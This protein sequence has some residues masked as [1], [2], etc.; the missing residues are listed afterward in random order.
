MDLTRH[1]AN[2][3]P[4]KTERANITF[5][6]DAGTKVAIDDAL[7]TLGVDRGKFF[8]S[9]LDDLLVDLK[10]EIRKLAKTTA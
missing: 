8:T 10:V 9:M 2:A 6:T 1:I 7:K 5:K 3:T 4:P